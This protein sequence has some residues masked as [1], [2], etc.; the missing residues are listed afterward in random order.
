MRHSAL[1]SPSAVSR[2]ANLI[3]ADAWAI[4][5]GLGAEAEAR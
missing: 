4:A 3:Q 1:L 2:V 5:E